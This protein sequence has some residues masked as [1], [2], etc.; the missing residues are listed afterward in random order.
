MML[1]MLAGYQERSRAAQAG[2]EQAA[3]ARPPG[4]PPTV[5]GSALLRQGQHAHLRR[6][7]LEDVFLRLTGRGLTE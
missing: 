2:A 1:R 7:T 5:A 4:R 6:A 3:Q